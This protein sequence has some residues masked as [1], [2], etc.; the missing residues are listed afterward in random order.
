MNIK[1]VTIYNLIFGPCLPFSLSLSETSDGSL[2]NVSLKTV[3]QHMETTPKISLYSMCGTRKWS[4]K[5]AR[6]SPSRPFSRCHLHDFVMLNVDLTQNV[7]YDLYRYVSRGWIQ[8]VTH[9]VI[10][11]VF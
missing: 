1:H 5:L 10:C 7:Q 11:S 4:S 9:L 3:L 8:S 2:T 6:K